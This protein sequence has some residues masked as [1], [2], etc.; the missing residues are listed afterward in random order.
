MY[1]DQSKKE[2][3]DSLKTNEQGLNDGEVV[4]I[5]ARYGVNELTVKNKISLIKI[6]F[7]QFK[8]FLIII[9]IL[10]AIVSYVIGFFPNQESHVVDSVLIL[11]IVFA[12]GIFGFFQNYKAEKSIEALKKMA[13]PKA[14]VLRAGERRE[15]DAKE[16]VPGDIILL[17]EGDRVPADARVIDSNDLEIDESALTGESNGVSKTNVVLNKDVALAD[18]K[19]MLYMDTGVIRGKGTAVVVGTGMETEIGKIAKEIEKTEDRETPFQTE[20]NKL[21]KKIGYGILAMVVLIVII[22]M[23]TAAGGL[24][25]IFLTSIALAVAAIPEGLPAVVTIALALGTQRM[26]RKNGLVRRLPVVEGLGSVDTI[27]VDKT[28]TLTENVMTVRELYFNQDNI[29]VTGVGYNERGRF[30]KKGNEIKAEK[31]SDL[32]RAGVLCNDAIFGKTEGGEEKYLGDPTEIAL[33]ISGKKG[34]VDVKDYTRVDEIAFSSERKKMTVVCREGKSLTAFMKGAPEVVLEGCSWIFEEGRVKRLTHDKR[35]EIIRKNSEMASKA[36]RVLGFAYKPVN[37]KKLSSKEDLEKGMVF[38][39][40]QG[41]IDPP[42]K[43][44]KEAIESCKKAGI[45][46]VMIT[47]DHKLTA[48]A[49]ANEI[50][51]GRG[52]LEGKDLDEIDDYELKKIV[53]KVDI[54][55]RVSPSHKVRVLKALQD[56]GGIVAMTGDGVN[57]APALKNADV[58]IA[59]GVKGT[60]VAKQ[61]SD[62][63]LLD[64]N[65]ITIIEAIKEGRTIFSNIRNFVNYLLTSNFAEV[66]VVFVASLMGYLPIRAVHLLW[67]NLLTDGFPALALGVD[68]PRK[69]VM[70]KKPRSKK[71]GVINKRM[72]WLIG[73]TGSNMAIILL[74]I[75]FMN[76]DKG[77]QTAQTMVFTGFVLYELV[78]LAMIRHQEEL[79]LFSNGW[80]ILAVLFSIALQL[81]VIYTPLGV[82]FGVVPLGLMSWAILLGGVVVGWVLAILSSKFVVNRVC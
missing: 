31:V 1:Y 16:L 42:R 61:T 21:G 51:L 27:C 63:I 14:I 69:N 43:G 39:G 6:F 74:F 18:R 65:F 2:V 41:M 75:F 81:A 44:V 17:K 11:I 48:Q 30:F 52:V 58:G 5:R 35:R 33:L 10:A 62:M 77:L 68:P 64:D 8:D 57:D 72:A 28:G 46:V 49:V 76:L 60:D 9:L 3:L 50:K 82:F 71:E 56:N 78:R 73:L 67:I 4:D 45:R 38:L 36:L 40:L 79:G 29:E 34:F 55:A 13:A 23:F 20:L 59:M 26:V 66:L 15:V 80:L 32:L 19:N 54:F 53:E 25:D 47:G 37:K 12:N 22:Q 70:N 24:V 7:D